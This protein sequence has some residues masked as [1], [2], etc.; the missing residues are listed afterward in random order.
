MAEIFT[1]KVYLLVT[2]ASRGI[3][4]KIAETFAAQL[5]EKNSRILLLA[6]SEENLKKTIDQ[7]PKN[8][9]ASYKCIDFSET[10][11]HHLEGIIRLLKCYLIAELF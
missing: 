10:T 8:L 11:S 4:K 1:G 9:T 2:G 7:L 6:R 5:K 3:G